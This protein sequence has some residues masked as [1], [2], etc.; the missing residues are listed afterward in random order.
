M[1]PPSYI[2][3]AAITK[4]EL[5]MRLR[6]AGIF[7][8]ALLLAGC[9]KEEQQTMR[10]PPQRAEPVTRTPAVD[11]NFGAKLGVA[12]VRTN[13]TVCVAIPLT[14]EQGETLT[15][16]SVPIA[17]AQAGATPTEYSSVVPTR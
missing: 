15:L 13:G 9:S 14:L 5:I 7:G 11:V 1:L 12:R 8:L 17:S 6:N 10:T 3:V 4:H 2:C 16:V